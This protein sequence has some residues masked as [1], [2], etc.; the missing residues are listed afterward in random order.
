M[1]TLLYTPMEQ[2]QKVDHRHLIRG[3]N[4]R[5]EFDDAE[6]RE[7]AESIQ[8]NGIAQPPIARPIPPVMMCSLCFERAGKVNPQCPTHGRAPAYRAV[9]EVVAGERRT[10]AMRDYLK[11]TEIP[12]II[13]AL[14]NDQA[15][16]IMLIENVQRADLNPMEEA[17]AYGKRLPLQG[18]DAALTAAI[19][20]LSKQTGKTPIH[21]RNRIKLLDLPEQAQILASKKQ[22]PL[23][24]AVAIASLAPATEK[25]DAALKIFLAGC[26]NLRQFQIAV[27]QIREEESQVGMFDLLDL[28]TDNLALQEQGPE[29]KKD[30]YTGLKRRADLPT[31][32]QLK[33]NRSAGSTDIALDRWTRAAIKQGAL[34]DRER[35]LIE[36]IRN[37]LL[38]SYWSN[39]AKPEE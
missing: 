34:S 6:L 17:R 14:S 36:H 26:A 37:E 4:D 16:A 25:M 31:F 12:V 8:E 32:E 27:Q 39:P 23:E 38:I 1:D 2:I 28:W 11:W 24:H 9:L 18:T 33:I 20:A 30:M 35:S 19:R 21:I 7:L 29:R 10:I 5:T 22:L 3:D 13:R 15:S